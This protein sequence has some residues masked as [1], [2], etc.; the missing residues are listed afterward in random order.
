MS[1]KV[2]VCLVTYNRLKF[3]KPFFESFLKTA[4]YNDIEFVLVDNGSTD[5]Q[6]INYYNIIE[7]ELKSRKIQFL[8]HKIE[9]NN[10]PIGLKKAR[11][12]A[13]DIST[14]NYFLD[15]PDDHIFITDDDWISQGIEYIEN[16]D[17]IGCLSHYSY[18]EYRFYKSNNLMNKVDDYAY[19]SVYKG[20]ADYNLMSRKTYET[21]G[22]PNPELG[23][24]SEGEYMS[25]ALS[26]GYKRYML[27]ISTA[28]INP[29][30]LFLR[31]PCKLSEFK[32][33][34]GDYPLSN[35]KMIQ[36]LLEKNY[37]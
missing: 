22:K 37:V 9:K 3:L 26:K 10:Y 13:K 24:K 18:P 36:I 2:S 34:S 19:R 16:K 21:I 25:R 23:V 33:Y 31:S 20:Y 27:D 4:V 29:G 5:E 28:I 8:Y 14:G 7:E 11:N 30:K 12:I 1:N 15:T 6:A 32:V 35:E 17:D